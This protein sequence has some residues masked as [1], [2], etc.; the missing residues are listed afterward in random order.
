[1]GGSRLR[2]KNVEASEVSDSSVV[3][4]DGYSAAV[5]AVVQA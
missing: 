2:G 4:S 3:A 5:A 1:M